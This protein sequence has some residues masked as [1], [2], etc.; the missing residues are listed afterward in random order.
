[1]YGIKRTQG[2]LRFCKQFTCLPFYKAED[3]QA[4]L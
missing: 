3:L 1:M 4:V 2:A